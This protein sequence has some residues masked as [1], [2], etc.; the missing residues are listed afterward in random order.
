YWN[1]ILDFNENIEILMI[2]I[3]TTD[4]S[5]YSG[6]FVDWTPDDSA[7]TDAIGSIGIKNVFK[8]ETPVDHK[9]NLPP[10]KEEEKSYFSMPK[11]TRRWRLIKNDGEM[12]VPYSQIK[13]MHIWKLKR[14][15]TL[16]AWVRDTNSNERLKWH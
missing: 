9:H 2:D 1:Y 15:A 8:Y 13:T 7:S 12:Y 5:L 4:E 10:E 16:K 14:G 6:M 3:A 11:S